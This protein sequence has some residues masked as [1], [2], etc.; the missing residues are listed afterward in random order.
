L[1]FLP[2]AEVAVLEIARNVLD[3]AFARASNSLNLMTAPPLNGVR[4]M[5][6]FSRPANYFPIQVAALTV[7]AGRM[8]AIVP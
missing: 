6:I 3:V 5:A 7:P 8:T 2:F 4:G 1:R